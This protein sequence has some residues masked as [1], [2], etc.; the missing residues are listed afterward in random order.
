MTAE[1]SLG[2][3]R[4]LADTPRDVVLHN[5]ATTVQYKIVKVHNERDRLFAATKPNS[6]RNAGEMQH[7][8]YPQLDPG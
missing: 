3:D 7:R 8:N 4:Q 6:V 2:R 1:N 5:F